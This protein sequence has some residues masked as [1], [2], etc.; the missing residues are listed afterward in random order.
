MKKRAR[1]RLVSVSIRYPLASA[2]EAAPSSRGEGMRA[3]RRVECDAIQEMI[4]PAHPESSSVSGS[5]VPPLSYFCL[6]GVILKTW[7]AGKEYQKNIW[8]RKK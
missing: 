7:K 4:S 3:G 1:G 6:A 8:L 5:Q 2:R